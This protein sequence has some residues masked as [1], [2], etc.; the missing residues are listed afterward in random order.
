[1][2]IG[3]GNSNC[4]LYCMGEWIGTSKKKDAA[5]VNIIPTLEVSF[6]H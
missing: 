3:S 1:M 5:V 2:N 6:A 4:G